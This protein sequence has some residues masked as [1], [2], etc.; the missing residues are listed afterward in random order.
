[1]K[2]AGCLRILLFC[3]PDNDRN[4][5][6]DAPELIK[7]L[8]KIEPEFFAY[9]CEEISWWF[10]SDGSIS[11]HGI[12]IVLSHYVAED[13]ENVCVIDYKKLFQ[14]IELLISDSNE[15]VANATATC[16][17]ENLQN[18]SDK[19]DPLLWTH[20]LGQESKEYAIAW[21]KFT[22]AKTSGLY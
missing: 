4:T 13:L 6:T 19:I 21:D 17:I 9:M 22:G 11:V 20:Y 14:E 5:M 16:F 1:M 3:S 15:D 7:R 18:R 12:F 8:I 2:K 10:Q